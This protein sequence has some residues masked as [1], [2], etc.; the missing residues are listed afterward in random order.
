MLW[1]MMTSSST[2]CGHCASERLE[3]AGQRAPVGGGVETGVVVEV[4]RRVAQ[5]PARGPRRDRAR[6]RCH[7]RSFRHRPWAS[8]ASLPP[9]RDRRR[10]RR[11][12]EHERSALVPQAHGNG[13][14]VVARDEVVAEHAVQRG[15]H[16]LALR[17]GRPSRERRPEL[18]EEH[19]HAAAHQARH[20]AHALVDEPRDSARAA[21][22]LPP[23]DGTGDRVMHGLHE[24]GQP[25]GR[26]R[27][28]SREPAEIGGMKMRRPGHARAGGFIPGARRPAGHRAR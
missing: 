22:R 20:A 6:A 13:E 17:R 3:Q 28:E 25:G 8:T 21:R 16:G 19:V 27:G 7:C 4:E 12:F 9:V 2:G 23:A 11:R 26:L 10:Q 1:A 18:G 24:I 5:R 15:Q 14:R